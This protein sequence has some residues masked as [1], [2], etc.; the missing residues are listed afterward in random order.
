MF[1]HWNNYPKGGDLD[2]LFRSFFPETDERSARGTASQLL[3]MGHLQWQGSFIW[4]GFWIWK[5][6]LEVKQRFI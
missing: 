1:C 6:F 4:K 3:L 5:G 2:L